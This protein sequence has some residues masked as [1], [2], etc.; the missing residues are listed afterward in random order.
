MYFTL[1]YGVLY[2]YGALGM[3]LYDPRVAAPFTLI[4]TDVAL[5]T[6]KDTLTKS[7]S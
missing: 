1:L 5:H 2:E 4:S 6:N 7:E 3:L